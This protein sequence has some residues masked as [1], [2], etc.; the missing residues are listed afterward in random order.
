MKMDISKRFR[1]VAYMVGVEEKEIMCVFKDE[2]LLTFCYVYGHIGHHT[3][4]CELYDHEPVNHG[5][6]SG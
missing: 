3:Q 2:R 5:V 6:E 1:R 4:K